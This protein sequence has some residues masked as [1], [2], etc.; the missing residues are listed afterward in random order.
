MDGPAACRSIARGRLR[1]MDAPLDY[2]VVGGGMFGS[3]FARTRRRGGPA[4]AGR[5]SPAPHRRQLLQRAA[6][7]ASRSIATDRTSFTPTTPGLGVRQSLRRVQSLPASRRRAARRAALFLPDQP[8]DAP[9]GV[10]RHDAGRSRAP[11]RRGPRALRATTTSKPGS[12]R[13]VGRELYETV[14]P[15]LHDQAMGPRS[16]RAAVVDH[17]PHSDPPD[18]GRQLLRRPLTRASPSAATRGCSRT[19]STTP[20]IHVRTERRLLRRP[21][22]ARSRAAR[23]SSTPARSTSSST[24]ASASSSIAR[25]GSRPKR[26]SG[27]F[28]GAAI[29]N[30]TAA[31]VPYTR[32]IEHKHF[33]HAAGRPHRDHVRVSA[34]VR[35]QAASRSTRF[36]MRRNTA[37]Y[38]RY[39]PTGRRRPACIFG[40][41]LATLPVLRHAPGRGPGA[42]HGRPRARRRRT[43][44]LRAA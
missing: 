1:R 23:G 19:C 34:A 27:D 44:A 6:S 20:N 41:R 26:L 3:V 9:P 43:P 35:P 11:A 16:R 39:R 31:D 28:Q 36:A 4:R 21:P 29:V 18:L 15:R 38:E 22:R 5:R 12:S 25:C 7:T 8:D 42:G 33:A 10:G 2:V 13:Q 24:T 14:R 37:V 17:S 32:I 30:Y 40:G